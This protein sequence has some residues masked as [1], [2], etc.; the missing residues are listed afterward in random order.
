MSCTRDW[1]HEVGLPALVVDSQSRLFAMNERAELLFGPKRAHR[2]GG[3][4]FEIV[5]GVDSEG[6]PFCRPN[7]PVMQRARRAEEI[8]AIELGCTAAGRDPRRFRV[9]T[10]PRSVEGSLQVVHLFDDVQRSHRLW[11]YVRLIAYRFP[12]VRVRPDTPPQ[13]VLTARESEV[14]A[15]LTLD[16]DPQ[17][18]ARLLSISPATARN[19]VR[20]ILGKLGAHSIQEAVALHLILDD[21]TERE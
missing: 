7:C 16:E 4:C 15:H 10:I 1:I 3:A 9:I 12:D 19:H 2:P 8:P 5:G 6:R 13:S 18:I 20:H 21:A 14:L 17:R 11:D